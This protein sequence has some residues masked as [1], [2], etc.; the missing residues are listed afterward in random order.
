MEKESLRLVCKN[1]ECQAEFYP[2]EMSGSRNGYC[3]YCTD[4]WAI[5]A[6]EFDR[7]LAKSIIEPILIE[8]NG[9]WWK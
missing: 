3:P 6:A 8:L 7:R 9:T 5:K 2:D 4:E 1:K